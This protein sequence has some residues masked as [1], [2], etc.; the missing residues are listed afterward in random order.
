MTP[1]AELLRCYAEKGSEEAFAELVKRYLNLVYSAALRQVN[2]D[3][4]VAQDVT[5]TV[6]ADLARK[7][8]AL[9]QRQV[10]AGWLYTSTHFAAAKVVRTERR[11]QTHEQEAHAM[12]ELLRS[13][14]SGSNWETLRPVLDKVMH[15][16]K[17]S[18]RNA[19][20][21]R[22]F[23]NR[24]LADIGERFGLSED[25][26]RKKVDRALEKLRT[27]LS[28]RGVTTAAVLASVL[29][30][31]AVQIAPM[32]LA[33]TITSASLISAG[34][35]TGTIT[36][37]KVISMTK[38]QAI[39]IGA[40]V[41]TGVVTPWVFQHQSQVKL[42]QENDSL[43]Q[44]AAQLR[45][46][47][48]T[49]SNRL[50]QAASTLALGL[51][52]SR[53][54]TTRSTSAAPSEDLSATNLYA[55]FKD[56]QPKLTAEQIEPYLKANGRN[57]ASLLAG[58]RTTGNPA[59]LEEA[60]QKYPNDPQVDFEAAFRSDAP[61]GERHQWLEAF[62]KS[63]PE[64]ALPNYLSALDYFKAGQPDQAVQE[65]NAAS[66]KQPFQDY[67]MDRIQDDYEAY[68]SASYPVA[69]AETVSARGLLL[70]QL[71]QV[72]ELGLNMIDLA[73]SYRSSGDQASAQAML[74]MA[75]NLG[76]RYGNTIAGETEVSRLV[77]MFVERSAL[78]AMDPTSPYGSDGQT[79]QDRMN[80][81]S[82]QRDVL[83]QL[84]Q[85]AGP[86]L[87][88]MSDQGWISYKERWK[89]FGEEAALRWVVSTYGQR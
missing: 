73:N 81:L 42:R 21:M 70:P 47:N 72:K 57:A 69:A 34:A 29:S 32:G 77:G 6:F 12:E 8:T 9:S 85:Q 61:A 11:R 44:E 41:I 39:T 63:A 80:Q 87:P 66:S 82:Q 2:G 55:R 76:Q 10:L 25:A 52:E 68:L 36:L 4:H 78:N 17:E 75:A 26:A 54:P 49:L 45:S 23:E 60:M 40:I 88:T 19:I 79:V 31:N 33:A 62:K 65:L 83:N 24:Q 20:L 46:D 37:L 16:L 28:K 5:Q 58:Y 71:A 67:S 30:T 59:L 27:F 50:A 13:P 53:I 48:D 43:R 3:T 22:Y 84:N 89:L 74:Q 38:L 7:A 64:N 35:G 14:S 15:E 86:L 51:L 18:D 1:D 56:K